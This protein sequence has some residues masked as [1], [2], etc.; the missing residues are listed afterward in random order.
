M[1]VLTRNDGQFRA[2]VS[3][4]HLGDVQFVY[5]NATF[6]GLDK[7]EKRQS[8]GAFAWTRSAKNPDLRLVCKWRRERKGAKKY[9]FTGIDFKIQTVQYIWQIRL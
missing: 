3:Q 1:G 9:F 5:K 4:T 2:K 8:K 7:P 6:C